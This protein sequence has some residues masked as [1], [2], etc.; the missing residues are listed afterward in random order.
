MH[1]EVSEITIPNRLENTKQVF[2]I[3]VIKAKNRNELKSF[4]SIM[5]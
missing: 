1:Y 2:H 4:L 5:E 3:Y